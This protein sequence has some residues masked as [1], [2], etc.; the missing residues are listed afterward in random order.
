MKAEGGR[1]ILSCPMP[2]CI[3]KVKNMP[4]HLSQ[5]HDVVSAVEQ[6]N[7]IKRTPKADSTTRRKSLHRCSVYDKVLSRMDSH[8]V[9]KHG[10]KR[11]TA[12]FKELLSAVST[13]ITANFL[14]ICTLIDT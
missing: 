9:S 4:R 2:F 1:K 11:G 12:R 5:V 3:A 6:R 13:S 8:L 10:L 7:L 14:L